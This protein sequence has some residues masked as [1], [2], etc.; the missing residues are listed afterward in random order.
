MEYSRELKTDW[1]AK[2]I[3]LESEKSS[4]N[5]WLCFNK[6]FSVTDTP[7]QF[8][9]KIAAENKYWLYIN[10]KSVVREGGLK[11]GPTPT[12]CYFDEVD[13]APYLVPGDNLISVLV[14]YWGNE[15]SY[16]S[17]DAGQGG[18]LFEAE[19]DEISVLSDN[20]WSVIKNPAFKDDTGKLS[21]ITDFP[22]VMFTM[23]RVTSLHIGISSVMIFQ[24]GRRLTNIRS[25]AKAVGAK[26]IQEIFRSSRISVLRIISTVRIMRERASA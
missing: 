2:W 19:N 23:M 5:V 20:S 22:K 8:N 15:A 10:G 12:G 21:R 1:K 18:L 16:S 9:A 6:K 24:A 4:K 25:A 14:W 13:I 7:E 3:W 17:S 26:S 11:R